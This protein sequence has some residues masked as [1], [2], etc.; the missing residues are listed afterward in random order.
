MLLTHDRK[1]IPDLAYERLQ[2]GQSMPGVV[3][4]STALSIGAAI[5]EITLVIEGTFDD[6]WEG[7]VLH[8]P[9]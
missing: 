3:V 4:V 8:F 1:T 6:E 2:E 7:Q 5:E 9:L